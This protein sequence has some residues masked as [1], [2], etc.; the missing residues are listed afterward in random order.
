MSVRR[1]LGKYRNVKFLFK[2]LIGGDFGP[3]LV[4]AGAMLLA[5]AALLPV[6]LFAIPENEIRQQRRF[7]ITDVGLGGDDQ[8][9]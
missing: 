6:K 4:A 1:G 9:A 8:I 5:M 2:R 3:N 7:E